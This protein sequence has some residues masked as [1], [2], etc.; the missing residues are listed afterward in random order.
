MSPPQS[1]GSFDKEIAVAESAPESGIPQ[2]KKD[3]THWLYITV[4]VAVIFC[5]IVLGVD[6]VARAATVGKVVGPA[7][8]LLVGFALQSMGKAGEPV[9]GVIV[10]FDEFMSERRAL[11]NAPEADEILPDPQTT[12]S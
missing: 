1:G 11:T 8:A 5:T 6:S 12:V 2:R 7:L 4:I 3:R 9:L 10:G